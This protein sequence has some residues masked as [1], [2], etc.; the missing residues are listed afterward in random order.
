MTP[1]GFVPTGRYVILSAG[2]PF[3]GAGR[4]ILGES[5]L[6]YGTEDEAALAMLC[7]TLKKI[8]PRQGTRLAEVYTRPRTRDAVALEMYV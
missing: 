4:D 5:P 2:R 7:L 6:Y 8:L 1:I 3:S